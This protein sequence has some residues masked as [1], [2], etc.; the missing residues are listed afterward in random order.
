[1]LRRRRG[2]RRKLVRKL[3]ELPERAEQFRGCRREW[4]VRNDGRVTSVDGVDD[5]RGDGV[6]DA[7]QVFDETAK[8]TEGG[9]GRLLDRRH[10]VD[11]RQ[12]GGVVNSEQ[13]R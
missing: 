1:M 8:V 3:H 5:L 13:P 2:V 11:G 7:V 12:K 4:S 10:D 6:D 9:G